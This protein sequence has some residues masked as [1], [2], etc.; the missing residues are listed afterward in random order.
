MG[1]KPNADRDSIYSKWSVDAKQCAIDFD[2]PGS[3]LKT[4]F[5]GYDA[6]KLG[7]DLPLLKELTGKLIGRLITEFGKAT[8]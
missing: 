6:T 1:D 8:A 5:K 2:T 3:F 4:Y 7:N